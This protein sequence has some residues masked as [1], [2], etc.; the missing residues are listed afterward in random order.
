M[1]DLF[2]IGSLL[3]SVV[4]TAGSIYN[5]KQNIKAQKE[6]N[7]DNLNFAY[8]QMAESTRQYE[9]NYEQSERWNQVSQNN[10][11]NATQIR[12][13][14]MARA[15]INP[16]A[17]S[18]TSDGQT[19]SPA[20]SSGVSGNANAVAPRS[21]VDFSAIADVLSQ[22]AERKWQSS[23]NDKNRELERKR[24]DLEQQKIDNDYFVARQKIF[25][26][27]ESNRIRAREVDEYIRNNLEMNR[28]QK[29]LQ[30]EQQR[31]NQVD[32]YLRQQG[33]NQNE[34]KL[35]NDELK[36][37]RDYQVAMQK[38]EDDYSKFQHQKSVDK[39]KL[40]LEQQKLEED[41]SRKHWDA[42]VTTLGNVLIAAS[43]VAG[44]V[45]GGRK[46]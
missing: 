39:S 20:Q 18:A 13:A 25:N 43:R 41:K 1:A 32:E 5:T 4:S 15:G 33:L 24:L 42:V 23:E 45:L 14:D 2:G 34:I 35:V 37:D 8:R 7:N 21:Q 17:M 11:E 29:E 16:L 3:G 46:R 10:F 36:N 44:S 40:S 6:V 9:K 31:R 22:L 38:L 26:D 27:S 28:L 12:A 30:S 19:I